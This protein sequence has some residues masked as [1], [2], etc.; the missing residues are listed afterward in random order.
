MPQLILSISLLY[1][2]VAYSSINVP[3]LCIKLIYYSYGLVDLDPPIWITF[4]KIL[5]SNDVELNPGDFSNS[6]F[7]F[8]NWN[9]NSLGKDDFKRIQ[10]LEAHKSLYNYDL[11]SLCGITLNDSIDIPNPLLEN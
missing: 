10:L 8:R 11:I 9:V 2:I 5:L 3:V 1:H 7:S 4:F 6:F